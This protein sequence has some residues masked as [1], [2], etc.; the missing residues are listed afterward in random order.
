VWVKCVVDKPEP[1]AW[2]DLFVQAFAAGLAYEIA[3]RCPAI[4]AA[5]RLLGEFQK[6][7]KDAGGVDAKE[8]P[9]EEPYDSSWVTARFG[10]SPG[11]PPNV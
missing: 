1:G 8:D 6:R 7:T 3:D 4:A 5:R 2:D 9:P 10:G 11:G